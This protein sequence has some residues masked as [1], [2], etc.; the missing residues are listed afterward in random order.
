MY[1][2]AYLQNLVKN[3]PLVSEKNKFQ[4][5]YVNDIGSRANMTLISNTHLL[6]FTD[7]VVCIYNFFRRMV[8][9]ISEIPTVF[10]F[11]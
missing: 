6:S 5:S 1:L 10:P 7:F 4:C 2:K 3:N 11:L 8:T 9:I